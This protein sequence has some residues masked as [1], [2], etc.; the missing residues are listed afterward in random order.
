MFNSLVHALEY[1]QKNQISA[2]DL[3][4]IDLWGKWHHVTLGGKEFTP[5]LMDQGVGFDGSS[6]GFKS[7]QSGDM[8]LIPD[9]TTG[10]LDPFWEKPTLSF[11][12]TV[13]EADS[14]LPFTGDPR[15]IAKNAEK[16]LQ[17]TGFADQSKWGPEFEFYVFRDVRFENTQ[18]S[19]S[20]QI[21]SDEAFWNGSKPGTGYYNP[22]HGG[23]HVLPPTDQ[24]FKIRA[25]MVSLLETL[26]VPIKYHHH[27]VGGPGQW[28]IE[29]PLLGLLA[30]G[31]ASLLI[32]YTTKM[33]ASN[34]G[35]TVTYL[36]KPL[37]GEAGSGLHFHQQLLKNGKNAFYDAKGPDKLSQTALYYIGGLLTHAPAVLAFTNPSTNS[38]KRLIPGFEAPVNCFFSS[39][40]RSAAIRVPKYATDPQKVRFEFRPP[41]A[42][43]N[44]Y[45]AMAAMLMAGI[46]GIEKQIDPTKA[47]FGP[48]DEDVL[49]LSPK[50]RN[51]IKNLP[52]T[53]ESAI[54]ALEKDHQFLLKADVFN[55][56]LIELWMRKKHQ[57]AYEVSIRPH[58]Y[59]VELYFGV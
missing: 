16:Y 52:K 4:F 9:L 19:S 56:D 14:K 57:E 36:P 37:F 42:T 43:C 50:R 54:D 13:L 20:Y 27:E 8:A 34:H 12:C 1:I 5:E 58:P 30:A 45:L 32:K 18:N 6:V 11:I 25:E 40:N 55:Q 29:T 22:T 24:F 48:I 53:L 3:K 39:G 23:Y 26:N 59:E 47:G 10:F 41:D 28:E 31:D 35:L 21:E 2:I 38:Y 17:S 49:S 7:V 46:D 44:P 51:Q 33:V 15:E